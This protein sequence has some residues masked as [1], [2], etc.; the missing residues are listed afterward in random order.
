MDKPFLTEP[1]LD[2]RDIAKN[3]GGFQALGGVSLTVEPGEIVGLIGPNGSGKTTLINVISGLLTADGG[4]VRLGGHDVTNLPAYRRAAL[5]IN[6]TFQVPKPFHTLTV[7][8][9]LEV[10]VPRDNQIVDLDAILHMLEL[11]NVAGRLAGE[12]TSVQQKMLDLAR[13]LATRPRLLLVDELACGLNPAELEGVAAR[14]MALAERD[15]LGLV[16]VEHLM[17]FIDKITHR[18]VVMNAG[19]AIF[20]GT[21][22]DAAHDAQVVEVFLGSPEQAA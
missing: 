19:R 8:E 9:N 3:F 7:R 2:V 21:L 16:V 22:R 4:A 6:R 12:L 14:L 1:L 15:G 11:E 18:V 10:A 13:A 17:P 5:G 20:R